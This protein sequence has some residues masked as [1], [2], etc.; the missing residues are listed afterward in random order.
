MKKLTLITVLFISSL[1]STLAQSQHV[2][3]L[4]W[5]DSLTYSNSSKPIITGVTPK[6]DSIAKTSNTHEVYEYNGVYYFINSWADY[7]MWYTTKYHYKFHLHELYQYYYNTNDNYN[8]VR[9]LSQNFKGKYYPSPV[10]ATLN[11]NPDV[12]DDYYERWRVKTIKAADKRKQK[13]LM[14]SH[15]KERDSYNQPM[16]AEKEE[17][18]AST[19]QYNISSET[20]R[21]SMD[22]S[23]NKRRDGLRSTKSGTNVI[24]QEHSIEK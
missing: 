15:E 7:Y 13:M 21:N 18:S 19:H 16:K 20:G 3:Y 9:F 5:S 22:E 6:S 8:M 11:E 24:K 1:F 2:S 17:H 4:N 14:R 10:I 23:G 12:K